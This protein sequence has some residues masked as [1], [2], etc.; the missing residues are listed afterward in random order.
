MKINMVVFLT[1]FMTLL[2]HTNV[3]H[4]YIDPV[5]GSIIL[6]ALIAGFI[7][8]VAF[9]RKTIRNV[10]SKIWRKNSSDGAQSPDE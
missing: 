8:A 9:F 6:Q 7:G 10:A 5:S 3:A 4:A 2:V 1:V